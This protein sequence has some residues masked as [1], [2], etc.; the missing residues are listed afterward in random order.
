[1]IRPGISIVVPCYRSSATL[2]ELIE[3]ICTAM[4]RSAFEIILVE[5]GGGQGTWECIGQLAE[6]NERIVG[7]RLGRNFGQHNALLAGVR[8]ATFDVIVT[9]DDDLQNPPEE[10][11]KLVD[12]LRNGHGDVV[13]GVPESAAQTRWRRGSGWLARNA[14]KKVLGVDE[15]IG[16]SSFRAFRTNLREAFNDRLGPGVSLDALLS[17]GTA[18]FHIVKV[19]HSDRLVGGSNYSFR[20]LWHFMV[21]TMTGY[22]T[23]PLR[24][25]SVVGFSTAI[26]GLSLVV[27]FVL[28]PFARQTSVPGFPFLASTIIVF[29]GIQ[30]TTL[31]VI[32]EYLSRMHF[33][34]MNK[35]EYVIAE[36]CGSDGGTPHVNE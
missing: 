12:A 14:M 1:M 32:G 29:S 35:P 31:G 23:L 36:I 7:V 15:V 17:W 6:E 34:I 22:S 19:Q 30:L 24:F 10:I 11:F 13:Y 21:D 16:M 25:V 27:I 4:D 9:L 8:E 26:F 3:R 33:R 20:K 5:D 2:P 28:V 18:D